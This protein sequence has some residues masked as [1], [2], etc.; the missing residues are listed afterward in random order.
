ML[1]CSIPFQIR[2]S[3]SQEPPRAPLNGGRA[4]EAGLQAEILRERHEQ[5]IQC[6]ESHGPDLTGDE[7][8]IMAEE[9]GWSID[10]IQLHAYE[11][12]RCLFETE[13]QQ[14]LRAGPLVSEAATQQTV[15]GSPWT[16]EEDVLFETLVATYR[17]TACNGNEGGSRSQSTD[18]EL[19]DWEEL[20]AAH[21]PGRT[22]AQVR[23]RFQE[24]YG[25]A[26]VKR[27]GHSQ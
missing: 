11:Y 15:R 12:M 26:G 7:W 14:P 13:P 21:L 10:E 3:D 6:L 4:D 25:D 5:F 16:L 18:R 19:Y 24:L 20:V 2:M 27:K 22:A 8:P 1:L 9:L 17:T 23:Q